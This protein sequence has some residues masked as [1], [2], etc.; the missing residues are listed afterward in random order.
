MDKQSSDLCVC[1]CV[2][3]FKWKKEEWIGLI[4]TAVCRYLDFIL[5]SANRDLSEMNA[6][7]RYQ[8]IILDCENNCHTSENICKSL[9]IA[10]FI[11][12]PC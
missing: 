2:C 8:E 10:H 4:L 6:V 5:L 7:T 11:E 1:V 3:V 9:D 12:L